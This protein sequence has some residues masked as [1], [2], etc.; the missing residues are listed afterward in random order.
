[1]AVK[2]IIRVI[3]PIK[4]ADGSLVQPL[5]LYVIKLPSS[6]S[7][8]REIIEVFNRMLHYLVF[9]LKGII[10]SNNHNNPSVGKV[11]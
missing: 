11:G 2:E 10:I 6:F 7:F 3:I 4:L 1:M 8:E 5:A 9:I